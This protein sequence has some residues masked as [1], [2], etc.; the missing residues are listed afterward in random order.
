MDKHRY[1]KARKFPYRW[2]ITLVI[3][4]FTLIPCVLFATASFKSTRT[5]WTETT[6]ESYY[7][8]ADN[9]ALLLSN[10]LNDMHSKMNYLIN[11]STIR[12]LISRVEY[13]T[14]PLS[15]DMISELE[16][17]VSA[18]T[19]DTPDLA[20]R[21]Y[22]LYG[23]KSYGMYCYPLHLFTDEFDPLSD[24][25][26]A[27][28]QEITSLESE[29]TMWAFRDIS[30]NVN[31][32]GPK[33]KRLCLYTQIGDYGI[34]DCILELSIPINQSIA[35]EE[36]D[37]IP[38]GLFAFCLFQNDQYLN[39]LWN[40]NATNESSID[41]LAEYQK[42]GN[43]THY[44]VVGTPIPN[45]KNGEVIF[46]LPTDYVSKLIRPQVTKFV[47]IAI[48]IF[49]AIFYIAYLT[50]HLLTRQYEINNLRMELELLQLR[51]NPHLLYNT[52][53]ALCC[54]IKNPAAI[55]TIGSLCQ[56]YRIVLNNGYLVIPVKDEIEMLREYL[57]IESYAYALN[58]IRVEYDI[59]EDVLDVS[60]IKHLLQ[61]IVENSLHH[62]LRPLDQ[63]GILRISVKKDYDHILFTISDNGIGMSPEKVKELLLS[64][65]NNEKGGY[66][67]YNVQQRIHTY[68]G[69]QY[70]LKINSVPT[71][72]TTITFR[73]P[74]SGPN[75]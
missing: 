41:L 37:D 49:I 58:N 23:T 43:I 6:L 74:A 35:F 25:D 42:S 50:S 72:G 28:Y 61:P 60:I 13:L 53:N 51:F 31:N 67:I 71:M 8:A 7:N 65:K 70:G 11:N 15:L 75:Q 2:K 32:T 39:M 45:I 22:P 30:R 24:S 12:T 69:K 4:M 38:N 27:L 10:T 14:L 62:G 59:S 18:I 64:P 29:T 17:A 44:Y 57:R 9:T 68:Y 47:V 55:N 1:P 34:A 56:Y 20:V 52:L 33:E 46:A 36:T 5:K 63:I 21:W 48:L 40:N 16:N 19:V 66:G 3:L 54:Q 73:L 26:L